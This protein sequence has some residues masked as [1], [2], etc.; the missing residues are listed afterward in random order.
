MSAVR[1]YFAQSEH[2]LNAESFGSLRVRELC[3]DDE[4]T[5]TRSQGGD[6]GQIECDR[7]LAI[8]GRRARETQCLRR[9][10]LVFLIDAIE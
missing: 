4:H 9:G 8:T 7:R 3:I 10:E 2:R 1:E 5:T 6:E